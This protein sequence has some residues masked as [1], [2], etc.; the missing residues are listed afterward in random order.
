M[1]STYLEIKKCNMTKGIRINDCIPAPL[2][3]NTN[4]LNADKPDTDF[5]HMNTPERTA[6]SSIRNIQ[7]SLSL[8]INGF[9][10]DY[11]KLLY[12]C[13]DRKGYFLCPNTMNILTTSPRIETNVSSSAEDF[14]LGTYAF[15]KM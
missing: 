9:M 14:V 4:I 6:N 3:T 7:K 5:P 10:N 15:V 1:G 13:Y 8:Q 11:L 2:I 12:K